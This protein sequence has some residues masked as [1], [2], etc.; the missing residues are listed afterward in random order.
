[1]STGNEFTLLKQRRF[2]PFF[3]TQFLGAFNDNV[4][5]NA[6]VIMI[7]FQ[8]VGL[9][10]HD[11]NVLINLSAGLLILPFLLFSATAGQLCDKFEKSHYIRWVK[12]LEIGIMII[13]ALGFYFGNTTL[14]MALLFLLGTQ[15]TLFGP[16]KYSIMPQHLLPEE[17]VGGNA[18]IEMGTNLAILLGTML[19]GLLIAQQQG[20]IW[21]SGAVILLAVLG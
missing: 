9:T 4:F 21:V 20:A 10:D 6:L 5:K 17:L 7:A 8:T 14:L 18:W 2:L 13:G 3:I 19:G 12:I 1:M 16:A 11:T 15:A